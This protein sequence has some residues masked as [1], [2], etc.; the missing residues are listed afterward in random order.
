MYR[1]TK[2]V[3]GISISDYTL[4]HG[5]M[6]SQSEKLIRTDVEGSMSRPNKT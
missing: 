4:L 3:H 1:P 5:G 2:T 6:I